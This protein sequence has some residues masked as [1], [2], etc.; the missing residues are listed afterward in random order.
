[1]CN[2]V[3]YR[4]KLEYL[5]GTDYLGIGTLEQSRITADLTAVVIF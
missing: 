3:L 5:N 1:M 4:E 2:T